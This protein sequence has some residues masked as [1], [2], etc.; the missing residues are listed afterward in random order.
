LSSQANDHDGKNAAPSSDE[1]D[2]V[3]ERD[4][5]IVNE[6]TEFSFEYEVRSNEAMATY[7]RNGRVPFQVQIRFTKLDGM[8]CMRVLSHLQVLNPSF[9]TKMNILIDTEPFVETGGDGQ[10]RSGGNRCRHFHLVGQRRSSKVLNHLLNL[11]IATA[12]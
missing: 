12:M 5:G 11:C 7:A 8:K 9:L 10:A 1:V 3:L 2:S 4:I 6:D